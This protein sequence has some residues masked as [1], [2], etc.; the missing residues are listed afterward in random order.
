MYF[1]PHTVNL[2]HIRSHQ[3]TCKPNNS[4]TLFVFNVVF[5]LFLVLLNLDA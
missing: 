2:G 3:Y 1:S 5:T 4:Q